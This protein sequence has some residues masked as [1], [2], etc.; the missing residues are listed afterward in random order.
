MTQVL[1]SS[2]KSIVGE[3]NVSEAEVGTI[4]E[5]VDDAKRLDDF[6]PGL[7]ARGVKISDGDDKPEFVIV[8][9]EEGWSRSK[10]LYGATFIDN[11]VEQVNELQPVGHLGH[12]P[13]DQEATAFPEPQTTWI[14]AVAK[15]EPSKQ[16][17]RIGEMVR[18]AYFAGYNYPNAKIREYRRRNAVRG[19]SWWGRGEQVPIPGKGVEVRGFSLKALDW[20]RKLAEGMPTSSIVAI[21]GEQETNMAKELAQVTPD[22]FKAEN[23]NGYALLVAQATAE[24]DS[25]I[26]EMDD[27]IK[28]GDKAKSLLTKAC[29]LLGIEKPEEIEA[30]ITAL[31]ASVGAKA[32]ATLNSGLDKLLKEKVPGD[33]EDDNVIA[34]RALMRRLLPVA[35]METKLAGAKEEDADKLISEMVNTAI[36]GDDTIKTVMGEMAPP[37]VRRTKEVR[38]HTSGSDGKGANPYI[39]DRAPVKV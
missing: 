5:M 2:D 34:K 17:T 16:K 25:T 28:E 4:A 26:R 33:D 12:I 9:V 19:I 23:P 27:K 6:I 10:R 35:E 8:R 37:S 15:T 22:E 18:T 31:K 39:V 32:K 21:T 13:D 14:G 36:D 29:E 3:M 20:A 30:Q 7:S 24:K 1:T 11:I 38:D